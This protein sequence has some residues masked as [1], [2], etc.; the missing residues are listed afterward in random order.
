MDKSAEESVSCIECQMNFK[1]G[2][3][4]DKHEDSEHPLGLMQC[5]ECSFIAEKANNLKEHK[6][7][8]HSIS[9]KRSELSSKHSPEERANLDHILDVEISSEEDNA[10]EFSNCPHCNFQC[11]TLM[12]IKCHIKDVHTSKTPKPSNVINKELELLE[13]KSINDADKT[14]DSS[15]EKVI[16]VIAGEDTYRKCVLQ[17][18]M[19]TRL[20]NAVKKKIKKYVNKSENNENRMKELRK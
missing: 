19:Y 11:T 9:V 5:D 7:N 10:A 1:N 12:E 8:S 20:Y 6:D 3:E 13:K 16:I 15:I 14:K 17:L 2:V 4:R 18:K